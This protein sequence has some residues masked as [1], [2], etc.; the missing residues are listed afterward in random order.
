MTTPTNVLTR[1]RTAVRGPQ[2]PRQ[3]LLALSTIVNTIGMGMFLSAG[4]I[5]LIR[6]AGLS[7]T[8]TGVGLTVGSLAGFGAGVL[9]GDLAD[10]RGSREVVIASMLLEAVASV[11]LL[12]VH[13]L[14]PLLVIAAVAAIGRAGTVSARGAMIGVL[15][16]EGKGPQLRTYLRA[17]TNVGLAV[18]TIGAAVVLAIDTRAAYVTMILIDTVTFLIAA[19]ILTRLPRLAPTRTVEEEDKDTKSGPRWL[20]LRDLPYL[21]L[22]A[23]SSV[24]S[25]Q[26]FVLIQALPVWI[27]L[28]TSAPRWMAAI[29]LFLEAAI[30]AATQVPATRSINGPRS[31]ARLLALSGPL[32]LVSWILVAVSAGPAAWIAITLLLIGVVVHSLGE[33]WQAAG[34]FEL[35]FALAKPEAQGQ[36]QGVMGL[37]HGFA[38]AVAP[39]VVITMCV[40]WG[41]PGW[42]VLAVVVTVAGLLCALVERLW[43][44]SNPPVAA[45]AAA[46]E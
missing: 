18:G 26:Y 27:V 36:Y 6:S 39:L 24:A 11:S 43:S 40:D 14:W 38:E 20:A 32:F 23:A 17:V 35:S 16:E 30:V 4:T 33:V 29:V 37:G 1:L 15:A 41:K 46:G 21:G 45:E 22:T 3:R 8:V 31:A 13:S 28:R 5:F 2:E 44:R 25:L 10:R 34:T 12:L 7:P 19:G 9:I 42:I